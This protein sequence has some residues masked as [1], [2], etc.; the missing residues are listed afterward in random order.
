MATELPGYEKRKRFTEAVGLPSLEK[1]KRYIV[2]NSGLLSREYKLSILSVVIMEVGHHVIMDSTQGV[3]INL[4]TLAAANT[5]VLV[6]IYNIVRAKRESLD[7][8]ARLGSRA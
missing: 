8:P 1:Q 5:E 2:E 4:D 6:H 3:S 7:Q